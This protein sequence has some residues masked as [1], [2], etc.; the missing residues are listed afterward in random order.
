M[1]NL[2]S[3]EN[4]LHQLNDVRILYL[5]PTAVAAAHHVGDDPEL[6]ANSLIDEF[7]RS[8]DLF[9]FKP[10][11]RRYG[12]NHPN[13]KDESGFHGYEAW[14]TI[15]ENLEVPPPLVKKRFAGGTYAAHMIA[16]G[17]FNE[18]D[19]LF[20]WVNRS[21]KYE[22]AGDMADQEHMCGLLEEHLNCIRHTHLAGEPE[23][24]QLDLLMPVREKTR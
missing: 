14:A 16:M 2:N 18:W 22:F 8:S 12:F 11:L 1:E 7:V 13:P 23:D 9:R 3:A 24:L 19:W 10:D 5:P 17:N 21:D 4:H 20:E 15:P 6:H